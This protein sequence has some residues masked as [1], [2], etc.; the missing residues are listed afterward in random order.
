MGKR[1]NTQIS[2]SEQVFRRLFPPKIGDF[3]EVKTQYRGK[4]RLFKGYIYAIT[5]NF[6][7]TKVYYIRVTYCFPIKNFWKPKNI[8]V[9]GNQR[10]KI[11]EHEWL[12]ENGNHK[13]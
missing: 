12:K 8:W 5:N 7:G 11:I 2:K 1:Y 13:R 9:K 3:I 4:H 6:D 10:I